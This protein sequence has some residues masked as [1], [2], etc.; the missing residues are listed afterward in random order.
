MLSGQTAG[1]DSTV[2]ARHSQG[3]VLREYSLSRVASDG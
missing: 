1:S 3:T 2:V